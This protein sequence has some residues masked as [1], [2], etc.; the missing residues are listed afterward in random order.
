MRSIYFHL[1]GGAAGDMLL[2]ALVGLGCPISYLKKEFKKLK[3]DFGLTLKENKTGHQL[4]RKLLFSGSENLRYKAIVSLIKRSKLDPEIKKYVLETYALI[5][6]VE[7]KIHK[8]R[9]NDFKFHHLGEIDAILEICGLY[10]ALKYLKIDKVYVS[11]FPLCQPAPA[12]LELLKGRKVTVGNFGYESVT[13]TAAALLKDAIQT[14]DIFTFSKSSIAYGDCGEGDYLTAYLT[15]D[16]GQ[17]TEVRSQ[18]SEVRSQKTEDRG[19]RTDDGQIENDR[20]IKIEVNI[21][22]MNPQVFESLFDALYQ[23]G[24]KEVYVEQVLM[25]KNRPAFVLNVLCDRG[26]FLKIRDTIFS[27]TTTFGIRYQEYARYKLKYRFISKNTKFG[28]IKFRIADGMFKKK[29]PEYSDCLKAAKKSHV[30]IL[31]VYKNIT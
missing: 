14:E 4:G 26:D 7:K 5:F 9:G 20:V 16:R 11:T 2:S 27:H 12:T 30:P 8:V 18:R 22:D 21:D 3:I 24:A 23:R 10:L 25:K 1:V 28:R 15:E 13:P 31:E 6:N 29:V 19:Q 17:R